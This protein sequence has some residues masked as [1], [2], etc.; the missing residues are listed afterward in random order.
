MTL[1]SA[2][3]KAI[4]YSDGPLLIVAG[5]G[6]GKTSVITQ[7]IA[8]LITT[9]QARPEEILAVTFTDKA[10]AEMLN[11]VEALFDFGYSELSIM[12]FHAFAQRLLEDNALLVGLPNR[13][14]VLTTTQTWLLMRENL[15]EFKLDF[16]RP[17]ANPARHIHE[18]IRHFSKCKDE[19][20]TPE[21]YLAYAEAE[22]HVSGDMN[23][24]ERSRL[25]ELAGAYHAYN[26]LLLKNN[27][28]DFGDLI[29]YA[30][31]LLNERPALL[32]RLRAKYRYILVD[33]FQDVNAAQ[34]ALVCLLAGDKNQLTVVGDD[35]QSIYAFRGASVSNILRFK[36]DFPAAREIVLTE[37]YRS[38]QQILD[39]AYQSIVHNNPDRLE[40]KLQIDKR[41]RAAG[42]RPAG[43]NPEHLAASNLTVETQLVV[44][45]IVEL[46]AERTENCWADS[47][48]LVRANNQAEPFIHELERHGIPFEF[49]AAAGLYRQAI[50]LD[51]VNFLKL[52]DD[53]H[54]SPAIFR[55][56]CLPFRELGADDRHKFVYFAKKKS[57]S[58]FEALKQIRAA[59]ISEAGLKIIEGLR[60]L[61]E[62]G[63]TKSSQEKPSAILAWF[64]EVSGYFAYLTRAENTHGAA[65]FEQI[66]YLTQF[67]EQLAA[68]EAAHPEN[69]TVA[70]F[71]EQYQYVLEAGDEGALTP[72]IETADRVHIMTVHGAKGL[73]FENVFVVNL[74]EERFPGRRRGE[75][76][77]LP[78]EL[79]QEQLPE[80]DEHY[81]EERRLFYVAV[82]R[83]KQRLFFS[84]AADYGG[85]RARKLS[86]FLAELGFVQPKTEVAH[87]QLPQ[88]TDHN[89]SET[90][91]PIFELP[92]AFSF[93][94]IKTYQTCPYQYKL[95]H[96][97]KLPVPRGNPS[98]SFG[99]SMH[100]ALQKFYERMQE[101]NTA[102]QA[103]LF[104]P[105]QSEH[106]TQAGV[107]VPAIEELLRLYDESWITDWYADAPQR[108]NYYKKGQEIL[109][110]FY[111]SNVSAWRVPISLEGWFKI[112]LGSYMLQGRIDRIDQLPDGTLEI[113]DYKTGEPKEKLTA[114]DK[115]QLLIYQWAAS[116]VGQYRQYGLPSQ[117]TFYYLNNNTRISFHGTAEEI[118]ALQEKLL[119]IIARIARGDFTATPSPF[120][121]KHCDFRGICEFRRL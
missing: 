43:P 7:K 113:I 60:S 39:M 82:T 63:M 64:L 21:A 34:Y 109:R 4:E 8:Q 100:R 110:T 76:I 52:T 27:S 22:A 71:L 40:V 74:V 78:L 3:Q 5:A 67:F 19:L 59:A 20:I 55:L 44:A 83:A 84:S 104:A 46:K 103:S 73:E 11:R 121:C 108:E 26:Q 61:I 112:S 116:S 42:N 9:Q 77:E 56:L 80:G 49:R 24:E 53:Y 111:A 54:E 41:L 99:Q 94:Q 38:T 118:Q 62:T 72:Q 29:F 15:D 81:Q 32:A 58:Y 47:A 86:R 90:T 120:V 92:T 95:A 88:Q 1:N 102:Q 31:K 115:E 70:G 33:E 87:Q 50:V 79:I 68:Y 66:Q 85:A 37:N 18:L 69:P 51:C 107:A 35:D 17:L 117:L 10:S 119:G 13:F 93:S 28:L 45:K 65:I 114:E 106:K 57:L 91:L 89:I 101:L 97:L 30:H 16:Y 23:Q 105:P 48:I 14:K 2:Q 98:F 75:G 36:D 6:T 12:T 25:T 96:V